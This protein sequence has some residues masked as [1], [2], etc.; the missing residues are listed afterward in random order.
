MVDPYALAGML[1]LT[2]PIVVDGWP[3]P[4]TADNAARVLLHDQYG[5]AGDPT[6]V[7]F[8]EAASR[9]VF[10]R[11][12]SGELPPPATIADTLGPLVR[13][14]RLQ[15]VAFEPRA[16]GYLADL[17]LAAR[18]PLP[19]GDALG[20]ATHSASSSKLDWYLRRAVR[21][22]VDVDDRTGKATATVEVRITNT[23]PA[24]ITG[25]Y[26]G[27]GAGG[28][29]PGQNRQMVSLYTVLPLQHLTVDGRA[30]T[31]DPSVER[32]RA[33][34][35][36]FVDLPPETTVV[37]RYSLAGSVALPGGRYH[38]DVSRQPT[39]AP[40]QL[41]VVVDGDVL[42]FGEQTTEVALDR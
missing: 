17:D 38:L 11:L 25:D 33:V 3:E 20:L 6:R 35:D 39:V 21:Y 22:D 8:L 28:K 14:R 27:S 24:D 31:P 34:Y 41:A 23:A 30:V 15:I 19:T 7:D 9:A 26:F 29:G 42:F 16:A 4:L 40:D 5:R 1:A 12:T 37:L 32:G 2:G 18:L 13:E 10:D 36:T